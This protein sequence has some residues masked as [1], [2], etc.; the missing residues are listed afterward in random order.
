MIALRVVGGGLALAL[1]TQ[2]MRRYSRRNASRLNLIIT[3]A[4]TVAVV[5]MAIQPNWFNFLFDTLRFRKGNNQRLIGALLIGEIILFTLLLR[6]WSEMWRKAPSRS[7]L[8]TA[9][10]IDRIRPRICSLSVSTATSSV[11]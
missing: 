10:A 9:A 6:N 8:P 3:F 1:L 7:L 4:I 5:L 2:Q 11:A